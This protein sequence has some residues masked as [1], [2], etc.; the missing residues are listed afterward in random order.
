RDTRRPEG[1]EAKKCPCRRSPRP[2]RR[3]AA[4]DPPMPRRVVGSARGVPPRCSSGAIR[5]P[6]VPVVSLALRELKEERSLRDDLIARLETGRH[7]VVVAN[8]RAEVDASTR[9]R[10]AG[11]GDEHEWQVLIIAHDRRSGNQQPAML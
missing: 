4:A 3:P 1:V 6:H 7:L 11:R 8:A 10:S 5:C 2:T 9:E